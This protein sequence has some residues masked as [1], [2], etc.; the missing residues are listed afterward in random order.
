VKLPYMPRAPHRRWA[1]ADVAVLALVAVLVAVL[2][3]VRAWGGPADRPTTARVQAQAAGRPV[4]PAFLGLSLEYPALASY[5]G[6]DPS[7]IDPV[8]VQ[9][10]RNLGPRPVLRLGGDST[11]WTWWPA[12][13]R[14]RPAGVTYSL[15]P[16]W[17]A[18]ARRVTDALGARLLLGINLEADDPRLAAAEAAALGGGLGRHTVLALELGN[19][20]ELYGALPWYRTAAGRG[21]RGRPS[22]Y[23]F[24]AFTR[25]FT[26]FAAALPGY[27][28]AGPT[29]SGP[30]WMQALGRFIAAEPQLKVLTLHRYPLQLCFVSPGSPRFPTVSRLLAPAAA[31]GL[32]DTFVPFAALAHRHRLTL[33]LDELNTVS[34]G[35]DP[36][37]S[38]TFAAALWAPDALFELVRAG[39]DGVNVHTF[40]GAGYELFHF[41]GA[42]GHWSARVA[43]EYYGLLMF[44]QAAPPGAR[45][46]P[47][48]YGS[49]GGS[50][51]V[52]ATRAPGR[53]VHVLVINKDLAH[54]RRLSLRI[55]G[56][57]A[58]AS[59]ERLTA[60]S[61]GARAGVSLGGWSFGAAT[62]T[63]LAAPGSVPLRA[64]GDEFALAV[65]KASAALVAVDLR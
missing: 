31:T 37:V 4:P 28:L 54:A 7:A 14:P 23:D 34:C 50:L 64:R 12:A 57:A 63:G 30:R 3:L 65:P 53:R 60:P 49:A 16:R 45:V 52:W 27:P 39:V 33:R 35:A 55:A 15:T 18:V 36:A 40:P 58:T 61:A 26:R 46:L 41:A 24:A 10:V 62:S 13:Q 21:V 8:F 22:G 17:L 11:D 6:Q 32:A 44:A 43:P 5:A 42:G 38:Q 29:V 48:S 59:L 1:A 56:A 9:L 2:V 25:D 20:P 47:V 51:K 19:E